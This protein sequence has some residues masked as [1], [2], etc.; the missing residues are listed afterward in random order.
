MDF[1]EKG[2]ESQNLEAVSMFDQKLARRRKVCAITIGAFTL[3][4]SFATTAREFLVDKPI[5]A[6][7]PDIAISDLNISYLDNETIVGTWNMAGNLLPK[8]PQVEEIYRNERLDFFTLQEVRKKDIKVLAEF[9]KRSGAESYIYFVE[10]DKLLD[11]Q[12]NLII[13]RQPALGEIDYQTINSRSEVENTYTSVK[14]L[15][16]SATNGGVNDIPDRIASS[17]EEKRRNFRFRAKIMDKNGKISIISI[18]T[19]HV[20]PRRDDG[21]HD[22][23]ID[24]VLSFAAS[25]TDDEIKPTT[26]FCLDANEQDTQLALR[27]VEYN[28][29]TVI[30]PSNSSPSGGKIDTCVYRPNKTLGFGVAKVLP[31]LTDH[32]PVV[33][34]FG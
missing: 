15:F 8:M 16:L 18:G 19:G 26:I 3:L 24:K 1:K 27:A 23:Q 34:K 4:S 13:S 21:I 28:L 33:V 32:H 14:Q 12:G 2:P 5:T 9:L 29:L 20:S 31:E 30:L 11:G 25:P 7:E 22:D 10:S 17:Y 6:V